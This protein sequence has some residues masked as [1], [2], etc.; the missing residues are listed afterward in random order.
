VR[1]DLEYHAALMRQKYA[2]APQRPRRKRKLPRYVP[3]SAY[4]IC[5]G[6]AFMPFKDGRT[7]GH[8][9]ALEKAACAAWLESKRKRSEAT[10]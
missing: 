7:C 5:C 9:K 2:N 4:C 3:G 10:A 1:P 6:K 8:C